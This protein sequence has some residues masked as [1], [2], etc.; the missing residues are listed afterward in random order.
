MAIPEAL[1]LEPTPGPVF[2]TTS[3][4][5]QVERALREEILSGRLA[6]RERISLRHYAKTWSVSPT[7]LR[8]AVRRL[9][10]QGL[11]EISPRRGVFVAAIDRN[12]L[13]EIFDLRIALECLAVRLAAPLIPEKEARRV[14]E[15]YRR[16]QDAPSNKDREH[17]LTDIDNLI[18]IVV[19]EHCGNARLK[20]MMEDVSDLVRWSQ[21]TTIA[22]LREPYTATLP[23]H[24]RI[25]E[26]IVA[27]NPEAAAA[28]MHTH[29][30]NTFSRLDSMLV[31]RPKSKPET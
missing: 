11:V 27:R 25:A 31:S 8:D 20:K 3:L 7:P 1:S 28:A 10:A 30:E 21:R 18:H 17:T 19:V 12:A 2:N 23:E 29:L 13:K 5:E 14:L 4:S 16:A 26:A 24:I 9:G 22:H 6:P 15:L